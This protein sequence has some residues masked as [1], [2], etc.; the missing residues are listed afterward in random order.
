MYFEYKDYVKKKKIYQE[1]LESMSKEVVEFMTHFHDDPRFISGW[2]HGYFCNDDGGRLI[3]DI[4]SPLKHKCSICGKVYTDYIY[5]SYFITMF[6]N[7]A[8][9]TAIK[10]GVLY[11]VYHEQKYLDIVQTIIQFYSDNYK[12]FAVHAKE[13]VDCGATIDVGGVGKIMPQGLNEAIIAIRFISALE[14]V[15][16]AVSPEWLKKIKKDLFEPMFDLLLPQ[17]MHIHNIPVWINSAFGV[18]GLFFNDE[19]W[20]RE[21]TEK[22]FNLYEQIENGVTDSGFWYEGSIHYNFFALEGIMSFLTFAKSYGLG[23]PSQIPKTIFSMFNAAYHYAFN[24]DIF[25]N[26]SDGWPNIS[27]QTHS[28]VYYM[29]YKVFG[30][31][32]VPYIQHIENTPMIRGKLPLSE[33]Y[34]FRNEI[35]MERLIFGADLIDRPIK[36]AP[37]RKSQNFEGSNCAIL[38]NDQYN[39]FLKYGHQ[40]KSHAHPDKMNIEIMV[41]D[42]I[43][44][45]DLSNS[46]YASK[47]CNGWHRTIAAHNTCVVNQKPSDVTRSGEVLTYEEDRICART[48]A[49]DDVLYTRKIELCNED[50]CDTFT[51]ECENNSTIDWIFH[52]ETPFDKTDLVLEDAQENLGYEYIENVK[53]IKDISNILSL[54]NDLVTMKLWLEKGAAVYYAQTYN[55]PAAKMRDTIIIRK[56]AKRAKFKAVISKNS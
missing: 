11:N 10:A 45:K 17:K 53:K 44:T 1:M 37:M 29:G 39:V 31:S 19:K 23:V 50:I 32:M 28:Y 24:N 4:N 9:V 42:Q 43:L 47:L 35:S 55:N 40:T 16:D 6:R 15:E 33:P 49:Y 5:S 56:K 22:P 2:G 13:K 52:F 18:M 26:P 36:E 7:E 41:G 3:Y 30:E 38:R 20:I 34:Y 8:V 48:Q 27:L 54:S 14:L 25:P 21:A 51:V 46:G 12:Y